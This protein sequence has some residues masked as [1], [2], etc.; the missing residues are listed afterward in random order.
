MHCDVV[1]SRADW[2]KPTVHFGSTVDIIIH[3]GS[4]M[5]GQGQNNIYRESPPLE[6]SRRMSEGSRNSPPWGLLNGTQGAVEAR[7]KNE[8]K[9]WCP[10]QAVMRRASGLESGEWWSE[11]LVIDWTRIANSNL[12]LAELTSWV[13]IQCKYIPM[14]IQ[15]CIKSTKQPHALNSHRHRMAPS[16][17]CKSGQF[18]LWRSIPH[19]LMLCLSNNF[20]PAWPYFG[21]NPP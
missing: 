2:C 18:A 21:Q 4:Y 5:A 11:L 12:L 13:T 3:H 8:R 17:T 1:D 19:S 15:S 14:L 20:F 10:T 16:L 9:P 7:R 6:Q